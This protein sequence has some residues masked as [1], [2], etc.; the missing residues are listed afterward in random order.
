MTSIVTASAVSSASP[1]AFLDRWTDHATWDRWSPD[2]AWVRVDGPAAV[3]TTGTLKP[4]GGPRVRFVI[5]ECGEAADGRRAVY[6]DVTRLP[7][8]RLDF[9]HTARAEDDGTRLD[10]EVSVHGPLARIWALVLGGGFRA[11]APADLRR[12]VELVEQR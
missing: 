5:S 11:S 10:V 7:G 12:L 4:T 8:A 2:T 1:R 3:G 6:T 9:R